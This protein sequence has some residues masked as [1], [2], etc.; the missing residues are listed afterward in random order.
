[1]GKNKERNK[2]TMEETKKETKRKKDQ[3]GNKSELCLKSS[4]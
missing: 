2:E 4:M 3:A 1:M